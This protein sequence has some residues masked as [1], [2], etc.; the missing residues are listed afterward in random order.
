MRCANS[1]EP[2]QL[3]ERHRLSIMLQ[4]LILDSDQRAAKILDPYLN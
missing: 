3:G 2:I 1:Q 4:H